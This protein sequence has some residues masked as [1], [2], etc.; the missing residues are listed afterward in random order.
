MK[1]YIDLTKE[2]G[3]VGIL[4]THRENEAVYVG[5]TIHTE[6]AK[7][8]DHP[9]AKRYAEKCDFH[10]FFDGEELPKLYTVPGVEVGGHDSRGGLF[11][12]SYNFSLQKEPMYYIDREKNC[13]LITE[14][15][16][17]LLNMGMEWREKMVPT[18]AVDVF[19]NRAEAELKYKIWEWE[20]LLKEGDL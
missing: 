6:D 12:G 7:L 10:F 3:C 20:E 18:D 4:F 8:R 13:F 17:E 15:S 2:N 19:A 16:A 1:F 5:T 9:L 14:N 11:V